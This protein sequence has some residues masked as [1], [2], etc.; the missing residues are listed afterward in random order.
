MGTSLTYNNLLLTS[1]R[2][3]GCTAEVEGGIVWVVPSLCPLYGF[4]PSQHFDRILLRSSS[5]FFLVLLCSSSFFFV[6]L[7]SS[8]F[9]CVLSAFFCVFRVSSFFFVLLHICVLC[10][11]LKHYSNTKNLLVSS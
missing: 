4:D 9:F 6:L 10:T 5:S 7:R 3:I 2:T 8:A 11:C 1:A